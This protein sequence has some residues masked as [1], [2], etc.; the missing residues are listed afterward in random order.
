[1]SMT[2]SEI[3]IIAGI[4]FVIVLGALIWRRGS[5]TPS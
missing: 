3:R 1:M 2:G 5:K 4:L